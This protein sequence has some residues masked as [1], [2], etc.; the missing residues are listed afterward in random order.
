MAQIENQHSR[1]GETN[2]STE[3]LGFVEILLGFIELLGSVA[4]E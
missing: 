2:M 3:I 4:P 1:S